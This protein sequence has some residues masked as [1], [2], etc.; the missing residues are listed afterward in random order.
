MSK[1][2]PMQTVLILLLLGASF[3][4]VAP[5]PASATPVVVGTNVVNPYILSIAD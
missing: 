1:N 4:I 5:P 3:G 2:P